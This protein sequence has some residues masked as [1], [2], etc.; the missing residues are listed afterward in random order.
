MNAT[1]SVIF[2]RLF[3]EKAVIANLSRI[4]MAERPTQSQEYEITENQ[5]M[6]L[7]D[8]VMEGIVLD[9]FSKKV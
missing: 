9:S 1:E 3:F 5:V 7:I 2:V 4:S 8:A 6:S